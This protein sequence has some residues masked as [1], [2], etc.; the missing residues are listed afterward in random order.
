ML[1]C[2]SPR[3]PSPLPSPSHTALSSTDVQILLMVSLKL[4]FV[5]AIAGV[6][7][8]LLVLPVQ[9]A[10]VQF[11]SK[12]RSETA[13]WTDER[14]RLTSELIQVSK[15]PNNPVNKVLLPLECIKPHYLF[16]TSPTHRVPFEPSSLP[17]PNHTQGALAVPCEPSS[18][19]LPIRTQGALAVKMLSW[20]RLFSR[21][22]G[23][24]RAAEASHVAAMSRVRVL[25][26]AILFV[27]GPLV[28]FVTF[29]TY[30]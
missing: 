8:T 11:I 9:A 23:V 13:K 6:S 21:Q 12:T 28:S 17:Q 29:A 24:M 22:L 10:L 16:R 27:V 1:P 25:N 18:L 2:P 3:P 19:P 4:G 14:V 30:R 7:I 15:H 26:T 5:P 20:E